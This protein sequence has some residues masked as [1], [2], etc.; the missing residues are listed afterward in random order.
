MPHHYRSPIAL[1]CPGLAYDAVTALTRAIGNINRG[2]GGD[3]DPVVHEADGIGG[4]SE[5][6]A[7]AATKVAA[8]A[9]TP[10]Y[11]KIEASGAE[12]VRRIVE[13][14]GGTVPVGAGA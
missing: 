2:I 11:Y 8:R 7:S 4:H 5:A 6:E 14:I 10:R 12:A 9:F 13:P 1:G 3:D